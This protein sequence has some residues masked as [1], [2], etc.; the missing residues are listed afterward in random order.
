MTIVN[1][2]LLVFIGLFIVLSISVGLLLYKFF[3]LL[4][5]HTIYYCREMIHSLS[6][7]IP[8][9]L[10]MVVFITISITLLITAL[11]LFS[12]FKHIYTFRK[13]LL[14][15]VSP[16]R[17]VTLLLKEML[18]IDKVVVVQND[19]PFAFCFGIRSPKIYISTKLISLVTI[20]ELKTIL[21]HELYHLKHRDALTLLVAN[22]AASLFPFFP[23]L[24]DLITSYR[25]VREILADKAAIKG[26]AHKHLISI[27][28]KLLLYEP[29]NTYSVIPAI[30][31]PQTLDARIKSLVKG[32]HY[33]HRVVLQNAFISFFS[34]CLIAL[35]IITPVKAIE[36]HES[37]HD[38]MLL[39][40]NSQGCA[41][42]C[43][44]TFM[45]PVKQ[46]NFSPSAKFFSTY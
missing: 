33:R 46:N 11:K 22:I 7:Q 28:R 9:G 14:K 42:Y 27:F 36:L 37:G 32:V 31:D 29:T 30:A 16:A 15:N 21:L 17:S 12:M 38:V 6:F 34:L 26:N 2:Y 20:P 40:S 8:S 25:T 5:H 35:F 45:S 44:Q 10:G 3:P 39:C 23:I 43:R 19:K 13:Q 24:S 4:I 18:L 1:K 41:S